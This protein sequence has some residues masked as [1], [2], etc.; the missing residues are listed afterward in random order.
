[1]CVVEE[2]EIVR[3]ILFYLSNL[4]DKLDIYSLKGSTKNLATK[5]YILCVG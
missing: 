5:R 2:Q 1:M 4:Q 3:D